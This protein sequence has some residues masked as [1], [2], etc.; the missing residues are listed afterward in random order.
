MSSAR[1]MVNFP[2]G[3]RLFNYRAAAIIMRDGHVLTCH[4]DDDDYI[5]LPG[6]RVE[7]GEASDTA[8]AREP[9]EDVQAPARICR[10]IYTV[11]NFFTHDGKTVHELGAYYEV[12]LLDFPFHSGGVVRRVQDEGHELKFEWLPVEGDAMRERCLYPIWIRDR[13]GRLPSDT[14]HLIVT[15]REG[16]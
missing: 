6:G 12:V 7:L 1:T 4:E 5:M 16:D 8:L 13:F 10:L 3:D 2:V 14:E 9:A 11:E 15:E